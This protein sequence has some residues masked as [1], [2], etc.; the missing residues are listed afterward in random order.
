MSTF[1]PI[2]AE[3]DKAA[4][5]CWDISYRNQN[6]NKGSIYKSRRTIS[7]LVSVQND[8]MPLGSPRQRNIQSIDRSRENIYTPIGNANPEVQG[9]SYQIYI[10]AKNP[11]TGPNTLTS[12][13]LH[14]IRTMETQ[15]TFGVE[16][17]FILAFHEAL[18]QEILRQEGINAQ[19]VKQLS[20]DQRRELAQARLS[21]Y[22]LS[23][24]QYMSWPLT[25]SST[26]LS[27]GNAVTSGNLRTYWQ[28]PIMIA[29]RILNHIRTVIP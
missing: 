18:L 11:K 25:H 6:F 14:Y 22:A 17:E 15:L 4:C 10:Q 8:Y 29:S 24:P 20:P 28:E 9:R 13:K 16:L 5:A 23:R 21:W 27:A 1:P 19:I 3:L 2:I 7:S 12:L 26:G